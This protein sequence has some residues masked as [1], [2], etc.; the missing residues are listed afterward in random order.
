[1]DIE[2]L[3]GKIPLEWLGEKVCDTPDQLE[4]MSLKDL[5]AAR[6]D[7]VGTEHYKPFGFH[8]RDWLEVKAKYQP[9]DQFVHFRSGNSSWRV[10]CGREG[11][12][13]VRDGIPIGCVVTVMS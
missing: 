8:N 11:Y 10:M 6:P 2:T 9:G 1:M 13:L 4:E 5:A 3:N 12:A 7:W